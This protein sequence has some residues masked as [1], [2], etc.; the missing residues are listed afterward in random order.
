[1]ASRANLKLLSAVVVCMMVAAPYAQAAINCGLVSQSL[2]PCLAFLE[3]G[4]GPSAACCKG[5]KTLQSLA[6]TVQDKR[7]ACRCMKSAA[8]AIPGINHKNTAALPGLCGVRI[9]TVAG[10]QTDCNKYNSLLV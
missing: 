9:G 8:A 2:A 3:N 10:P 5:V 6:N 7:T 4:N 1:M